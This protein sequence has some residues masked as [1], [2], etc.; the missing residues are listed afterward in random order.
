[1]KYIKAQHNARHVVSAGRTAANFIPNIGTN[2]FV[3]TCLCAFVM[4]WLRWNLRGK[5]VES[6][7]RTCSVGVAKFSPGSG[8][9]AAKPLSL[10]VA[11][12]LS[13]PVSPASDD[14]E[15]FSWSFI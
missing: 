4:L 1:M 6:K 7:A 10:R 8:N 13:L 12:W 2:V 9:K 15:C 11:R 3:D 14:L 5:I